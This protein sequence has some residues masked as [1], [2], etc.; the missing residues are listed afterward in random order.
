MPARLASTAELRE[1]LAGY[2]PARRWSVEG[3][4]AAA[5]CVPIQ[6]R[7]SGPRIWAIKRPAGLRHHSREMAFPGGKPEPGDEDLLATALRETE[8]EIGIS[9]SL[10]T[11]LGAL[12]A[13]PTATSRFALSP[14][15]VEVASQAVPTPSPGEVAAIVVIDVADFFAGR[16]AYSAIDFGAYRSPIFTFPAGAMYGATAH[17]LE[18]VLELYAALGGL[19]MP[20]PE[21]AMEIP[22]A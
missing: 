21:L 2:E 15:L 17:I 1:A 4:R 19:T 18:E 5:V 8:E 22:W 14:F 11:P 12:P 10:L 6:D 9:R 16:I 3:R 20:E 13:V 7:N